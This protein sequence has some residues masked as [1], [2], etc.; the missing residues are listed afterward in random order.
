MCRRDLAFR[1]EVLQV[2]ELGF[3]A[4]VAKVS[5]TLSFETHV[6]WPFVCF[7]IAGASATKRAGSHGDRSRKCMT[8]C[9]VFISRGRWGFGLWASSEQLPTSKP[10][11]IRGLDTSM[12][13]CMIQDNII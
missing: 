10:G 11:A 8:M 9:R 6:P 1:A 7:L 13:S 3:K 12:C 5:T 4:S 2:Y